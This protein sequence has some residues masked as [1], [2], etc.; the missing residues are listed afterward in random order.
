MC[1]T[2]S[3]HL[4]KRIYLVAITQNM[5]ALLANGERMMKGGIKN[6]VMVYRKEPK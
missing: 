6:I 1:T 3:G 4:K 5:I 2:S